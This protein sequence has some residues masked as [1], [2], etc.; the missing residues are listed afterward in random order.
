MILVMG[1]CQITLSEAKMANEKYPERYRIEFIEPGI[2]SYKDVDQ[3]TVF[4]SR[5]AL[6]RMMS[7]FIGKPVINRLHKDLEPEEAF[8]L[9]DAERDSLADGVVYNY[10]WLDNGRGFADVII[11][12]LDTKKNIDQGYSASCA[13]M[14]TKTT[15]GDVWHGIP[16]DE[17]VVDGI[18]T[19]MAI[20]EKPRYEFAKISKLPS[21][22]HNSISEKVFSIYQNSYKKEDS[23]SVKTKIFKLFKNE[24]PEEKPQVEE[25]KINI[26]DAIL[27]IEG[28][29]V[30]LSEVITA[31]KEEKAEEGQ[32]NAEE[33]NPVVDEEDGSNIINPDDEIDID[34][35]KVLASELIAS[36]QRRMSRANAEPP[37]D[38]QAEPT[39]DEKL[40]K[41]NSKPNK[42]FKALTNSVKEGYTGI[43]LIVNT[44]AERCK[45]GKQK[46][47]SG[48]EAD[49]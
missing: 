26:D 13:Y 45:V 20:V 12:D 30:P 29:K 19:H 35:N 34:G 9:S 36:Y 33:E 3:G 47:G 40:Q 38:T 23:M 43:D 28:D 27:E 1:V 7:S 21:N 46:Y 16:Y 8:K 49:K 44:K 22:F 24:I 4:V 18:Y 17:E 42:H 5:K 48:K 37:T 41:E 14:P 2:I 6:D 31:Y 25:E 39:V 11:W 32:M 10:G 15:R